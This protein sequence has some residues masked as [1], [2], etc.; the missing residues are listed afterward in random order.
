MSDSSNVRPDAESEFDGLIGST[1]KTALK[2]L[3]VDVCSR[4]APHITG[5]RGLRG[6]SHPSAVCLQQASPT[7]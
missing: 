1:V 5:N 4:Q 6:F 2:G 7:F 3:F